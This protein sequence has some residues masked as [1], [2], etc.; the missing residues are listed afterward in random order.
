MLF[1]LSHKICILC[2]NSDIRSGSGSGHISY[3][4]VR[5]EHGVYLHPSVKGNTFDYVVPNEQVY[6]VDIKNLG[7][8]DTTGDLPSCE[9]D[10]SL[11]EKMKN[12]FNLTKPRL[13]N[14][15][16]TR[17]N[18]TTDFLPYGI[19]LLAFWLDVEDTEYQFYLRDTSGY[20]VLNVR[21]EHE[22]PR[23]F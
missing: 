14:K 9:K 7:E 6:D 13:E 10:G 1:E 8:E 11:L 17:N 4:R 12:P 15:F 5:G 20:S 23:T 2:N 18:K 22:G 19:R 21:F 16:N 3:I